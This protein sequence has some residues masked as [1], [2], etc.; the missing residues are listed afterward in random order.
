MN[1]GSMTH[2]VIQLLF[3]FSLV[4]FRG[5][6]YVLVYILQVAKGL[7]Q[8]TDCRFEFTDICKTYM[9]PS[10]KSVH[11]DQGCDVILILNKTACWG[12]LF[13]TFVVS[14]VLISNLLLFYRLMKLK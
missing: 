1:H 3:S 12:G 4:C 9:M 13:V 11:R 7:T 10:N 6:C 5:N 8:K 14:A 2:S